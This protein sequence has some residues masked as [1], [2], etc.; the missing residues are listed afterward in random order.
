MKQGGGRQTQIEGRPHLVALLKKNWRYDGKREIFVSS[1]GREVAPPKKLPPGTVIRYM[2]ASLAGRP[3]DELTKD[4][5]RLSRYLQIVFPGRTKP[6]T[7][8]KVVDD[9]ECIDK[10]WPSPKV[11][12]ARNKS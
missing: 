6:E 10:A 11:S 9:L 5:E 1:A 4:E 2:V 8:L 12:P 7:Y 3:S